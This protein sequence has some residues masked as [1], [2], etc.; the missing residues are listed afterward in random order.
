MG[1]TEPRSCSVH[2]YHTI[3]G[4]E[5]GPATGAEGDKLRNWFEEETKA[6]VASAKR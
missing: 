2:R 3:F 5:P 4:G 1:R 6:L